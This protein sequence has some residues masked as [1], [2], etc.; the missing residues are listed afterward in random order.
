M[1]I[2]DTSPTIE[3]FM[4]SNEDYDTAFGFRHVG[5]YFRAGEIDIFVDDFFTSSL[6]G[7]RACLESLFNTFKDLTTVDVIFHGGPESFGTFYVLFFKDGRIQ[8]DERFSK[9]AP[10]NAEFCTLILRSIF[11]KIGGS[12]LELKWDEMPDDPAWLYYIAL[13][14]ADIT[15][16]ELEACRLEAS[17]KL[18][19]SHV[20]NSTN[21]AIDRIQLV[22]SGHFDH[23]IGTTESSSIEFKSNVDL[24]TEKGKLELAQD[25]ARFANGDE[26]ASFLVGIRTTRKDGED[27]VSKITP[28]DA[29]EHTTERYQSIIDRRVYP[30]IRGL[31]IVRI[32]AGPGQV[33]VLIQIPAQRQDDKPFLVHGAIVDDTIEGVFFSIVRRRGEGS[34]PITAHEVHAQLAAGYRLARGRLQ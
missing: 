31:D 9:P 33:I 30:P 22:T 14:D 13:N 7:I 16:A 23:L 34:V 15:L 3:L 24:R 8:Y 11:T 12:V 5:D 28:V 18:C 10:Y 25:M 4:K 32:P 2:D 26:S 1:A 21:T 20:N 27:S 6:R 19:I 17:Q 29:S